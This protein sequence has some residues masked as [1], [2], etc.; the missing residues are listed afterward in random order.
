MKKIYTAFFLILVISGFSQAN[1]SVAPI[2]YQTFIGQLPVQG[3]SDDFN[4]SVI[5]L[6]FTIDFY[7]TNYD[8]I[9]VST[10]GYI[11]FRTNLANTISPWSFSSTIPNVN[12]PVKNSILGCYHDMNNADGQGTITYGIY[13]TVPYRKFVVVFH[14][15]SH[16]SC[17]ASAK[18]S[19]QMILQ[20]TSNIIEVQLVDKQVCMGW[21]GGR[22]VTGL[23]DLAGG[24]AIAAPGRNTGSWTAYQEGWRFYRSGYFVNY[25]Y[26]LCQG[27]APGFGIFNLNLV[28][29]AFSPTNPLGVTLYETMADAST[30]VNAIVGANYQNITQ[31]SQQLY[32]TFNGVIRTV[33]LSVI[34]CSIDLDNDTVSTSDEDVNAD[35]NLANDDTDFDGIP[36]YLDNDDDGDLILTN[37]E[38]V[39]AR[40][41]SQSIQSILDTDSDGIP[42]YLDN[43]DDGDGVLTFLEDYN[44]NGNPLDDDLNANGTADFLDPLVTLSTVSFETLE[45]ISIYPNP[46]ATEITIKNVTDF[47]VQSVRLYTVNG[48]L[49][50]SIIGSKALEPISVTDLPSGIYFLSVEANYQLQ[51]FKF[52]KK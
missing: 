39:F 40:G 17:N 24:N 47:E 25:N 4:S 9:V 45:G 31:N 52:V 22:A 16:F 30:G 3:T 35:G 7:G 23:I 29:Q 44:G 50:Q 42:N 36:N 6:P 12:F 27:S 33:N 2:P 18:S 51:N 46:A 49:I 13:G 28:K 15:N 19:F 1:Y 8:Q 5:A 34:N 10:N 37:L 26:V 43:D 38:Y 32:A 48:L 20:E 14:N 11:D 41:E 21:N